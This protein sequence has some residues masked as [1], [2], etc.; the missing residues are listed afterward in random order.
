MLT[1]ATQAA[2]AGHKT[3]FVSAVIDVLG[4][5]RSAG[6]PQKLLKLVAP[7]TM[8]FPSCTI[9][10][11]INNFRDSRTARQPTSI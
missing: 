8:E 10:K 1:P 3:E 7:G 6:Q 4:A 5:W 2:H 11:K 9:K